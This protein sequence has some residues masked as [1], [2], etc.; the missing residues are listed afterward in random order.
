MQSRNISSTYSKLSGTGF[1]LVLLALILQACSPTRKVPEGE[2]LLNKN[3]ILNNDTKL[4]DSEL[5]S[6][7]RQKP[8]KK[9]LGF[10][11]FHL[12]IYS[13][14]NREKFD[15]RYNDRLQKRKRL[16]EKRAQE[17]KKLRNAEPVSLSK[18]RLEVGESPV[19]FDESLMDRSSRQIELLLKNNGYFNAVVTDS[20]IDVKGKS[21]MK[22]AAYLVNAGT[23]YTLGKIDYLIDDQTIESLVKS[24]I[25]NSNL[26]SGDLYKTD[27]LDKERDRITS[28][29]KNKGYYS[30]VKSYISYTAD[31][32][33]GNHKVD[34]KLKLGNPV[35][36]VSGFVD[37]TV[38]KKHVRY[39][40]NNIFVTGDYSIRRQA[41]LLEDTLYFDNIH[42]ISEN[43]FQFRPR[44][45]K[46][47]IL[48]KRG[49]LYSRNAAENTYR[50]ISETRAF[51]FINVQFKP[52]AADSTDLLDCEIQLSPK[53]RHGFTVQTQGTNTAGN[54]GVALNFIYQN[55]NLLKGLE[56]FEVRLNGALEVQQ[57]V[58]DVEG[59]NE[60]IQ[61]F[62]PFNTV[63]FG[64]EISLQIPKVPRIVNFLGTRSSS[65]QIITSYNFQQRPDYKREIFNAIY[66]FT[67]KPNTRVTN[68][69]NPIEVNF[70]SVDLGSSFEQL[71][72]QSNNLFL[73]NSYQSQFIAA[74]RYSYIIN[75]QRVGQ[76]RNFFFFQGNVESSGLLMNLSRNLYPNP[77]ME[78]DKFVVFGVPYSQ[79]VKFDTDLRYY[80][81]IG[82]SSSVAMRS[83]VGLG[84]PYNNSTV[85]PF[86]KSFFA[87]GANGLR[88]WIARSLGPGGYFS[89]DGVRLDQIGDIKLEWNI[90]YRFPIYKFFESAVFADAGNIWLRQ[91]DVNRPLANFRFYRFYK[92]IAADVGIGFRFNFDFFIIRVDAAHPIREP[93]FI[94][95]ERWSFNRLG[96]NR[97]N[98]N[99]GIG[100]PF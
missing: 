77:G 49:D 68:I 64:P 52:T 47:S 34:I 75:T 76:S 12:W 3:I 33:A 43:Q 51:K 95:S 71:L 53:P 27:E 11:R 66:G 97:L 1:L 31:S 46:P 99:L 84:I 91:E 23:P 98:F 60:T 8:N 38:T 9:I 44:A 18:W 59:E 81:Y 19:I 94:E 79:Y 78:N 85:M 20:V 36:R 42:Y 26:H 83:L 15:P 4:S 14:V 65:T 24:D 5:E 62:L 28:F 30:F 57:I 56:L 80:R 72:D 6:Y 37:S 54:L 29:L 32:S 96:F 41:N 50:R 90:E 73:K 69:F 61:E 82:K 67:A 35:E 13:T 16:N 55:N 89:D 2:Y 40:I 10:W 63:M 17:G 88:G 22:N 70:V 93:G 39:K 45:I 86:A 25:A 87:G 92:E 58:N 100:Y 7:V 74:M 21:A 48:V